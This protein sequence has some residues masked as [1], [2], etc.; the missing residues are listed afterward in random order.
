MDRGE[1]GRTELK[2]NKA[3][4]AL[5][6]APGLGWNANMCPETAQRQNVCPRPE[7]P[8]PQDSPAV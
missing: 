6:E 8:C 4:P 2:I 1:G 3:R 7:F 5:N